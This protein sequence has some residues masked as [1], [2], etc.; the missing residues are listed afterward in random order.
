MIPFFSRTFREA[1]TLTV[2]SFI[3]FRKIVDGPTW[4][5]ECTDHIGMVDDG[6]GYFGI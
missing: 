2:H 3:S 4:L 5:T 6:F 1:K